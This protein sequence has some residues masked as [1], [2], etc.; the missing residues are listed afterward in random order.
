MST[1]NIC[2]C[3][4]IRKNYVDSP[5]LELWTYIHTCNYSGLLFFFLFRNHSGCLLRINT[6]FPLTKNEMPCGGRSEWIWLKGSCPTMASI[7]NTKYFPIM[8]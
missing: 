8:F 3:G 7:R 2:F 1:H 5:S 6:R 4:E